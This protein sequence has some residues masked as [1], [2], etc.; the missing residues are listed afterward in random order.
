MYELLQLHNH[1]H[2]AHVGHASKL[3]I[4]CL[5]VLHCWASTA[6]WCQ[7]LRLYH[8]APVSSKPALRSGAVETETKAEQ[9][10]VHRQLSQPSKRS[11]VELSACECTAGT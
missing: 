11:F 5:K 8:V 4:Y 1:L 2:C 7:P 10:A 3:S 6:I 9:R